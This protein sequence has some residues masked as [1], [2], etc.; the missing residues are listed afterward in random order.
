MNAREL[1]RL[2]GRHT[3]TDQQVAIIE[4]PH[5]SAVVIAGAG[6]GKTTTMTDR[7]LWLVA[8]DVV[9]AEAILGLTFTR[10]AAHQL[11]TGIRIGLRQLK[12]AG[13]STA[14]S[15]EPTISTYHAFGARIL[16]DH[17]LRAGLEPPSRT[18]R[19][20]SIWQMAY[21]IVTRYD[22]DMDEMD[23][24]INSIVAAVISMSDQMS[25]HGVGVEEISQ[26]SSEIERHI[27]SIPI[28]DRWG[29]RADVKE[30]LQRQ[31]MRL[32]LLP[33]VAQLLQEREASG[34]YSFGDQMTLAARVARLR[35]EIGQIERSRF[36]SV[37][38]DEYQDTSQS[39]LSLMRDLFSGHPVMAVGDP[40]QAIYGWRGASTA[41][42]ENFSSTFPR[43]DGKEAHRFLLSTSWRND[44]QIL[45]VAN[46]FALDL[47]PDGVPLDPRP[48]AGA[49]RLSRGLFET[50][51]EQAEGIAEWIEPY[52]QRSQQLRD[53]GKPGHS[54]AV[55]VRKKKEIEL[56]E[57]ALLARGM[58][59]EVIGVAGLLETP[60]VADL[61]SYLRCIFD[62][63]SGD[64]LMR[65]MTGPRWRI[66]PADIAALYRAGRKKSGQSE[67]IE[68]STLLETLD[69][70]S[71][72]SKREFTAEGRERLAMLALE[73]RGLRSKATISLTDLISDIERVIGLD[74]EIGALPIERSIQARRHVDRF[75][76]E[77][78][79][80]ASS[81]GGP[82]AFLAWLEAAAERERGLAVGEVEV[83]EDAVQ[84]L[85]VHTAKGLEWDV[86][87]LPGLSE[88]NFPTK[89]RGDDNWLTQYGILPFP[90]RGDKSGLP[91]FP[92]TAAKS[93]KEVDQR[94]KE[95]GELCS[96]HGQTEEQRLIYVALTRARH[97]LL[98][99]STWWREGKT[100]SGPSQFFKTIEIGEWIHQEP[101]PADSATNPIH[102][103]E[104]S[105][106]WPLD[107]VG[108]RRSEFD[109]AVDLVVTADIASISEV[110][111]TW[112][113]DARL[114][115]AEKPDA[116]IVYLPSRLSVSALVGLRSDPE[117]LARRIRR[118][119]P[120][121]PDPLARRG[122]AFHKWL[123]ER[124]GS[125]AL[126][127]LDE[128]DSDEEVTT[129]EELQK[130]WLASEW[131]NK[132]PYEIETPFELTVDGTLIRGRMDAVYRDGDTWQ[133]VDWKT[134]G[135]KSGKELAAAA[136]QLAVYRL[137]WA[138]LMEIPLERISAA[139]HHVASN[140]TVRPSDLLDYEGLVELLRGGDDQR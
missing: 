130:A 14:L 71:S 128:F 5:E 61:H 22:G 137:A 18:L 107:P 36:A 90:L 139:F 46:V 8:N 111:Q 121:K 94:V 138:K 79:D 74:I 83:R 102:K 134:G 104:I 56:I 118:P 131:A 86:V 17:A 66:G 100:K 99:T 37:L 133:I 47:Q 2:L 4:A 132:S 3:P 30:M 52:W 53:S 58:R 103:L 113:E 77:A 126:F 135:P 39:Q 91:E 12:S 49:G 28:R 123:E 115:L 68:R 106:S 89:D 10:K 57:R 112:L 70:F 21:S 117:E 65:I 59:V 13:L 136:I 63:T 15:G 101:E 41:T 110:G 69:Q 95:F 98:V 55:L 29:I 40:L 84:L 45:D 20:A 60:E 120:F 125:N 7:V 51:R 129:L 78:A 62:P 32:R 127:D 44:Q 124:L 76:G 72:L 26:L 108:E 31:R 23:T 97:A 25:E 73:L 109:K 35:P 27:T 140:E 114:L 64:A 50:E 33:M 93:H 54:I 16:A 38:L 85:T 81:G 9:P 1:A 88:G 80:F 11:E 119:M 19:E 87:V 43:A 92:F 116:N 122:T 34:E 82:I 105:A 67:E 42:I 24:S 6:S 75:I 96:D 48:D